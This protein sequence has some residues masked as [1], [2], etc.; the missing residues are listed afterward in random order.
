MNNPFIYAAL[1]ASLVGANT[2]MAAQAR[3][4]DALEVVAAIVQ[5]RYELF[6]SP[7]A[8]INTGQPRP[9][10]LDV[11]S[12]IAAVREV[13]GVTVQ[14][15]EVKTAVH[16]AE[17]RDVASKQAIR[18]EP[19]AQDPRQCSYRT[20]DDG[21][22]IK[23]ESLKPTPEGWE[24]ITESYITGEE[25]WPGQYEIQWYRTRHRLVKNG[26]RWTVVE[27]ETLGQS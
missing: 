17:Y 5:N 27:W 23:F 1:V 7:E 11:P 13:S 16:P 9:I 14:P 22:G 20:L 25:R 24:V 8:L 21:Y 18:C 10:L 26:G 19:W 6:R 3:A 12:V 15:G 4:S 2:E